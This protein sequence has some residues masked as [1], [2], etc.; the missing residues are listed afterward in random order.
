MELIH[1][2][3]IIEILNKRENDESRY[4]ESEPNSFKTLEN[5][6]KIEFVCDYFNDLI[7]VKNYEKK[8]KIYQFKKGELQFYND[9]S[10]NFKLYM[11]EI[12]KL[13]NGNLIIISKYKFI[14]F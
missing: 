14:I 6:N 11:D 4:Y 3:K 1:K 9:F 2:C 12:I 10:F 5:K 8:F 13:K 7:I